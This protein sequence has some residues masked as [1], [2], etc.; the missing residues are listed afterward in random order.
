MAILP[1][2][3]NAYLKQH[4]ALLDLLETYGL[5]GIDIIPLN[6]AEP[7]DDEFDDGAGGAIGKPFIRYKWLPGV[8][9][10]PR[11]FLRRDRIRYYVMDRDFDRMWQITNVLVQIFSAT[12]TPQQPVIPCDSSDNVIFN[13]YVTRSDTKEPREP[14]GLA[15]Q[16]IEVEFT[17]VCTQVDP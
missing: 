5:D 10:N 13:Y 8:F 4:D 2:D 1:Y 17:F 15:E 3:V 16:M 9:S 12:T 6:Q 7:C 14:S 11:V